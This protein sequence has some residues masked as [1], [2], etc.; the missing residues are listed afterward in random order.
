V[1]DLINRT[2]LPPIH[3]AEIQLRAMHQQRLA[4]Q[5]PGLI[6]SAE[7]QRQVSERARREELACRI[8]VLGQELGHG[9]RMSQRADT[10]FWLFVTRHRTGMDGLRGF[11]RKTASISRAS[12]CLSG[13]E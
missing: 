9:D 6:R 4:Q 12:G 1:A 2:G 13:S 11:A 8:S 3:L 10:M 5:A 7:Y